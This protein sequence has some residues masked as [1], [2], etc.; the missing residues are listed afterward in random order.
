MYEADLFCFTLTGNVRKNLIQGCNILKNKEYQVEAHLKH[1][2]LTAPQETA[3]CSV[4]FFWMITLSDFKSQNHLVQRNKQ[5]HR[6][7]LLKSFYLKGHIQVVLRPQK[8][9]KFF[10]DTL[11]FIQGVI[12]KLSVN[13]YIRNKKE[14][15]PPFL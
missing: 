13:E 3:Y 8:Y 6:K 10:Y 15:P 9:D 4:A 11:C 5:Y 1:N 7:V 12:F 14:L 2:K